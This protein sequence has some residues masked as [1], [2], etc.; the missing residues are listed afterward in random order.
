MADRPPVSGESVV[1]NLSDIEDSDDIPVSGEPTCDR[2]CLEHDE[3]MA[4][5]GRW[6]PV[7][8]SVP[9]HPVVD[10]YCFTC[11]GGC[12]VD[13][14]PASSGEPSTEAG[15]IAAEYDRLTSKEERP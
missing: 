3:H 11:A 15:E 7:D 4:F 10:G 14:P 13:P 9:G 2:P 1:T 12:A 6:I 5:D 8:R